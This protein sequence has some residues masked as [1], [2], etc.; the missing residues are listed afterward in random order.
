MP[1]A[2]VQRL[3]R[4]GAPRAEPVGRFVATGKKM[5]VGPGCAGREVDLGQRGT[6]DRMTEGQGAEKH[7]LYCEFRAHPRLI[8]RAIDPTACCAR[9]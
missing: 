5:H 2:A 1:Y 8:R 4:H 7:M 3:A 6:S 9:M